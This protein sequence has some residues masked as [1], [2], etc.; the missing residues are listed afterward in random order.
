MSNEL[1]VSE[2][3]EGFLIKSEPKFAKLNQSANKLNF[4]AEIDFARQALV[5]NQYL[6]DVA[7][8]NQDSLTDAVSNVAAIGISLNPANKHAYLVPRTVNKRPTVCLDISYMGMIKLATDTG[9]VA[10]MKAEMV[11]ENDDFTYLGFD[12][13][14]ELKVANPFNKESR[15]AVIGVIAWAKLNNGDYINELMNIDEL[16]QIRDDS[17]AYKVAVKKGGWLLDNCVWVKYYG[18][19]IKKTV[20]KRLYKTLPQSD[21]SQTMSNAIELLNQH[22]GIDFN[23][24]PQTV[25]YTEE[26]S[27]AYRI[28]LQNSDYTGLLSLIESLSNEGQTQLW[29]LHEEPLIEKGG[30]GRYSSQMEAHLKAA[31]ELRD[32]NLNLVIELANSGDHEGLSQIFDECNEYEK[33]FYMRKLNAE[34]QSVARAA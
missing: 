5:K 2:K 34:Q 22:E 27:D 21:G 17:E 12:S 4:E 8:Q 16:H 30:K 29:K 10:Y 11:H 7:R 13:R 1:T 33:S 24:A 3:L 25:D 19:M 18:E 15:G 23:A 14:P 28:A 32:D 26:D 9:I 6:M 20:I 31:R